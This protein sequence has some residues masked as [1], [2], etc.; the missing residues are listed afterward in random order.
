MKNSNTDVLKNALDKWLSTIPHKSQIPDYPAN[1]RAESNNS[2]YK[3]TNTLR[4]S[5]SKKKY[6]LIF[7]YLEKRKFSN[8]LNLSIIFVREEKIKDLLKYIS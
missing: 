4:E 5:R 6:L 2:C 1:Q 3:T 7:S 8:F